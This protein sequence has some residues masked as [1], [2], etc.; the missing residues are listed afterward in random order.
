MRINVRS[1]EKN[2]RLWI[3]TGLVFNR[4]SAWLADT[5]G[6]KYAGDAMPQISAKD[7][8]KLFAEL[9]RIKRVYGNWT[10][11]EVESADGSGVLVEL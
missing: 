8:N 9:R 10:L 2:I 6:R 5:V 7:M 4:G 11:V 1:G 3:P